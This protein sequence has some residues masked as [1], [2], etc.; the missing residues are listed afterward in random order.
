MLVEQ[1]ENC[2]H[3]SIDG[4]YLNVLRKR[5]VIAETKTPPRLPLNF[6][7]LADREF[8]ML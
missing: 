3:S 1:Q 6:S 5:P 4:Q 2:V 7:L 8:G